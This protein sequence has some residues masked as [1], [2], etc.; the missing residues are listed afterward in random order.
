MFRYLLSLAVSLQVAF[1][2]IVCR[3][4]P[5]PTSDCRSPGGPLACVDAPCHHAAADSHCCQ[6]SECPSDCEPDDP[7]PGPSSPCDCMGHVCV[8]SGAIVEKTDF[9][10]LGFPR[11]LGRTVPATILL[12][13]ATA[14]PLWSAR[15]E[16]LPLCSGRQVR[17]LLCSLLC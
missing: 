13:H 16:T 2:P 17:A 14:A 15:A 7:D 3:A 10:Q 11:P 6:P 1:C 9:D 4:A 12:P 8:W 5:L